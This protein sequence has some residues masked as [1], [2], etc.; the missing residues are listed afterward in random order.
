[1]RLDNNMESSK[2][3]TALLFAYNGSA[4]NGSQIQ[5]DHE[6]VRTVEAELQLALRN[7]NCI[8]QENFGFLNKVKW[9]RASRTDKGVHALCAVVG[10]KMLWETKPYEEILADINQNLPQDI[11][12][13]AMKMVAAS[14]HAKNSTSYREYQYL[15][16]YKALHP[17]AFDP[18][19]IEKLN[20]IATAF[21]G[22][23]SFHNYSR[24]IQPNRP[25]AKRYVIKFEV[26][27]NPVV[28]S[29][30]VYL[31]FLVTG[32][33]FLYHQIRKMIGMC[34]AVYTEKFTLE[35]VKK[36][37]EDEGFLVPLAPAQGLSLNR[38]H[39]PVYNKKQKHRPVVLTSEEEARIE[40]FYKESILPTIHSAYSVFEHW[41]N[42]KMAEDVAET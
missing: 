12:I 30:F 11:R 39:F 27:Q 19:I 25:E 42:T 33:S 34:L 13:I 4:F 10:L 6:N 22:T 23:H 29:D 38:V 7:A 14:F 37:F 8:S 41:V 31:K 24:D 16:P 21:H 9:T 17:T 26:D 1:M 2:K 20:K 15:F 35:D 40:E 28:F 32:Q 3:K 36:S 18:E 5:T